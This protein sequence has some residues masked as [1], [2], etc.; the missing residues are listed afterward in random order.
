[1]FGAE[2]VLNGMAPVSALGANQ[3]A[4]FARAD[5]AEEGQVAC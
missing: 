5:S 4:L 1:M 3:G 2:V